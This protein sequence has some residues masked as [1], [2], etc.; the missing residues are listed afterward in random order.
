MAWNPKP[1][2]AVARDAAQ[3]YEQIHKAGVKQTIVLYL[4]DDDRFGVA[5]YGKTKAECAIA[6]KRADR[7]FELV[8]DG[9]V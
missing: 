5:S 3:R 1:E 6:G 8:R 9:K 7:I 4:L 2:V